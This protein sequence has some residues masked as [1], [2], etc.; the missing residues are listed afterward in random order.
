MSATVENPPLTVKQRLERWEPSR[1]SLSSLGEKLSSASKRRKA[2]LQKER[3]LLQ[4][5]RLLN[6]EKANSARL[7]KEEELERVAKLLDDKQQAAEEKRANALRSLSLT[8]KNTN[9]EKALR[10]RCF[11]DSE[12]REK[13]KKLH[14]L[15]EKLSSATLNAELNLKD[16]QEKA[17]FSNEV[18]KEKLEVWKKKNEF[19]DLERKN[20]LENK[21]QGS[22]LRLSKG[23]EGRNSNKATITEKLEAVRIFKEEE[24]EKR[25]ESKELLNEKL[26][27]SNERRLSLLSKRVEKARRTPKLDLSPPLVVMHI[28]TPTKEK[29]GDK[30]LVDIP[31]TNEKAS[32]VEEP[33]QKEE[34]LR[35]EPQQFA[36]TIELVLHW[37]ISK[38]LAFLP[39][40]KK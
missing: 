11:S 28:V 25:K 12:E 17:K 23:E 3:M 38:L 21:L 9:D 1:M 5:K 15:E 6:K 29:G 33:Q 24:A 27:E 37:V 35:Q 26:K 8:L 19:S 30:E 16:V 39:F 14:S 32:I 40:W 18:K 7:E 10:S 4:K 20:R 31:L 34:R 2:R 22:Q 36:S 13:K